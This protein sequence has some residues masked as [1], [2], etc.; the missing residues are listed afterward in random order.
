VL[1]TSLNVGSL[2]IELTSKRVS[3]IT[4]RLEP[5]ENTALLL[6]LKSFPRER[7]LFVKALPLVVAY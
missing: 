3:L 6:L 1:K 2:A 4:S 5:A 7:V